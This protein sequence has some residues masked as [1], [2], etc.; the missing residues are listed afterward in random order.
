MKT[1]TDCDVERF[2]Y[3]CSIN[4]KMFEL[5]VVNVNNELLCENFLSAYRSNMEEIK[6]LARKLGIEK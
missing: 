3:L 6:K 5:A 4:D 2:V 1:L